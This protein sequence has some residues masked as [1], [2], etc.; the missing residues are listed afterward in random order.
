MDY[1]HDSG[2]FGATMSMY[3]PTRPVPAVELIQQG[4]CYSDSKVT[5]DDPHDIEIDDGFVL[6]SKYP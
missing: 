2:L 6:Q 4:A 1:V 3:R 5:S